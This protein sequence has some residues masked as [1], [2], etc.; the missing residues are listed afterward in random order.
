MQSEQP[1]NKEKA[2]PVA[3]SS[4]RP[5]LGFVM[6][7]SNM[8]LVRDRNWMKYAEAKEN[9]ATTYSTVTEERDELQGTGE[10]LKEPYSD[11][12]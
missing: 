10:C 2:F 3:S 4:P 6:L 8:L 7:Q 1:R 5:L 9:G 12:R 11:I